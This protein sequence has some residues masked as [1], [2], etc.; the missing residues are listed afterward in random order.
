MF[1]KWRRLSRGIGGNLPFEGR[2]FFLKSI[3][4]TQGVLKVAAQC[5]F[6]EGCCFL[7]QVTDFGAARKVYIAGVGL[8][9][10]GD[11]FEE[12]SFTRT[13]GADQA[14]FLAGLKLEADPG[15][16]CF[17]AETFFDSGKI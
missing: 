17:C 6:R 12:G 1:F 11:D 5:P 4:L 7:G 10:S 15:K 14:C 16:D 9:F 13:I 3:D 2:Y 8:D